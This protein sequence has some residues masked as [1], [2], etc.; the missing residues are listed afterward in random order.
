LSASPAEYCISGMFRRDPWLDGCEQLYDDVA[1]E[2]W[3]AA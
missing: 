1:R 2:R 3:I